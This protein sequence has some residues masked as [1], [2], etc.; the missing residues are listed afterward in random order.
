MG[1]V[2]MDMVCEIEEN[3]E[4]MQELLSCTPQVFK[5][6]IPHLVYQYALYT[7]YASSHLSQPNPLLVD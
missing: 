2:L 7:N 3:A 5:P 1:W 6:S 4:L